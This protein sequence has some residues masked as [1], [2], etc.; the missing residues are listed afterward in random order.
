MW[1]FMVGGKVIN[2]GETV[3]TFRNESV[4]YEGIA[5]SPQGNSGG[6][7]KTSKGTFYPPVCG[8]TI[9]WVD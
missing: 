7:I 1:K 2:E 3:T 5:M 6:K 9:E 4:T 8:G